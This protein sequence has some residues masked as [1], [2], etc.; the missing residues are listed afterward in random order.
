MLFGA[1]KLGAATPGGRWTTRLFAQRLEG[2]RRGPSS[3]VWIRPA[4]EAEPFPLPR[5]KMTS[6]LLISGIRGPG[7][8][9]DAR[10]LPQ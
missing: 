6:R 1:R 8:P 4:I 9:I 3:L 2:R 5:S 10:L 7:V